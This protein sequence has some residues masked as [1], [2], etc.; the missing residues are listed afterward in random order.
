MCMLANNNDIPAKKAILRKTILQK[1]KEFDGN[2]ESLSIVAKLKERITNSEYNTLLSFYPLKS[3]PNIKPI[4]DETLYNKNGEK[5]TIAFP[6]I[7][8]NQMYFSKA[9]PS[10]KSKLGF[11]EPEHTPLS[12]DK[13]IILVPLLA[14]DK[15]NNRLGRGGGFYDRFINK[16]KYRLCTIGIG[17]SISYIDALPIESFDISLDEVI[18]GK[19]L[20]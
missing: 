15:A 13:A 9:I 18:I 16:N 1:L 19:N 5:I 14:F 3:E 4:F 8:D 17:Y 20:S 10:K 7:E 6:Y 12:F 11:I 2:E